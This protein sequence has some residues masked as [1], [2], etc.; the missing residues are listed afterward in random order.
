LNINNLILESSMVP[1][2]TQIPS[3]N[4]NIDLLALFSTGS[5][6]L[7][8]SVLDFDTPEKD[9]LGEKERNERLLRYLGQMKSERN[10]M[11]DLLKQCDDERI[12]FR[13]LN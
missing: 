6:G 5:G 10:K 7:F 11:L 13:K 2:P 12:L 3:Y 8:D 9:D 4:E 1:M